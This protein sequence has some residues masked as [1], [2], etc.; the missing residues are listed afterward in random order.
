M[1][2]APYGFRGDLGPFAGRGPRD[3]VD[4]LLSWGCNAVFGG[5]DDTEFVA[6]AHDA[7]M[8]VYAEF[9]C[10]VGERWW[11]DIPAS[12]PVLTEGSLLE[13]DGWYAGVNPSHPEVR[14]GLLEELERLVSR[15]P[16][17]GVWLDFIRWPCHWE[18]PDPPR[19]ATSFDVG[20]LERF[21]AATGIQAPS[22]PGQASELLLG[23]ER[24]AW[25]DWRCQQITDWVREA[26]QLVRRVRPEALVG[27]F[28]IPW[29]QD[30]FDGAL[31]GVVGQDLAALGKHVD[32]FS[33]MVYH[34]M[35]GQDPEW[36]AEVVRDAQRTSGKRVWPIIQS[37]DKP[38]DLSPKAYG[39]ALDA[40]M[41]CDESDGLI[42]F[43]L[44]GML[45]PTKVAE[46]R[47]RWT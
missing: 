10:F 19:P 31:K 43:T 33:P 5:Y 22:E 35:C 41:G 36:I 29:R 38:T 3:Q 46:T 6:A 21:A 13:A 7:G 32:V 34:L 45:S 30:D 14:S 27:L 1:I 40:A 28:S 4:L 17:D 42:V 2:R 16:I 12:R 24:N 11:K 20:T 18:A 26:A 44:E 25:T 23:A 39:K 9:G 37:V 47:S 15:S 8:P